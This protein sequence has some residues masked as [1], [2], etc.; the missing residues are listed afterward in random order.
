MI[1]GRTYPLSAFRV[2]DKQT[3]VTLVDSLRLLRYRREVIQ[4]SPCFYAGHVLL[5]SMRSSLQDHAVHLGLGT[6]GETMV[7]RRAKCHSRT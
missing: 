6:W 5:F 4:L 7:Y 3:L 2:L 1:A